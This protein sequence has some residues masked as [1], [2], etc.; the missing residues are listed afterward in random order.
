MIFKKSIDFNENNWSFLMIFNMGKDNNFVK[1]TLPLY[2]GTF[3]RN[4]LVGQQFLRTKL[5]LM[6]KIEEL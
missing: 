5:I 3:L 1:I 4:N 2:T 6:K